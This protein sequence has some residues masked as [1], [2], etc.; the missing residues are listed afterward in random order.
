LLDGEK[1][2]YNLFPS[3]RRRS[4]RGWYGGETGG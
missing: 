2:T 3:Q 1:A 4:H